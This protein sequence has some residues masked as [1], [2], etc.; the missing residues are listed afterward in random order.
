MKKILA[1]LMLATP[2]LFVACD[3]DDYNIE[4]SIWIADPEEYQLPQYSENGYNTFGA[5]FGQSY[6]TSYWRNDPFYFKWIDSTKSIKI[7]MN[8]RYPNYDCK[9]MSLTIVFPC[10]TTIDKTEKLYILDGKTFDLTDPEVEISVKQ[11]DDTIKIISNIRS[12]NLT[13]KRVQKMY[14]DD[15][16]CE[17]IVSGTFEVRYFDDSPRNIT[18][19]R[20]DFGVTETLFW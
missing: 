10:N 3:T 12:G 11:G 5:R 1:M 14:I 6:F 8:G 13:F 2:T 17:S 9:E 7:T 19:G 16:F 4:R 20:F 18:K 15:E